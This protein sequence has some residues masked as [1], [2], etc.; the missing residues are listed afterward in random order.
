[1]DDSGAQRG[2]RRL[3]STSPK[4]SLGPTGGPIRIS[5]LGV[6]G[7]CGTELAAHKHKPKR[8]RI[9]G[10]P[11]LE[12]RQAASL[13]KSLANAKETA[14]EATEA[15]K[16]AT[17]ARASTALP[18]PKTRSQWRSVDG[19][20][21]PG[22][23]VPQQQK[24]VLHASLPPAHRNNRILR[25]P[26]GELV[27]V[28]LRQ[29]LAVASTNPSGMAQGRAASMP[30]APTGV[31]RELP[32]ATPLQQSSAAL[33][34]L[35]SD[36]MVAQGPSSETMC[37][38]E[39]RQ[40]SAAAHVALEKVHT[41]AA[42]QP[43]AVVRL[44]QFEGPSAEPHPQCLPHDALQRAPFRPCSSSLERRAN[45]ASLLKRGRAEHPGDVNP[46]L[47][48]NSSFA[49]AGVAESSST[50]SR[51]P[52]A[53]PWRRLRL[54]VITD[55]HARHDSVAAHSGTQASHRASSKE[56]NSWARY[57][58]EGLWWPL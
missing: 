35:P 58:E 1:M 9:L 6:S 7:S 40:P 8:I 39:A 22:E 51:E 50:S 27:S 47:P 16:L 34:C 26:T 45:R 14:E 25:T 11:P 53:R 21:L 33:H 4:R 38:Q 36:S 43:S 28:A 3:R 56:Q 48:A 57:G 19:T 20:P 18:E 32:T 17:T 15:A 41:Q 23:A 54:V 49:T 10:M 31:H 44:T 37:V 12:E 2:R 5:S 42:M 24:Q 30:A 55:N 46:V 13:N 29:V 52:S